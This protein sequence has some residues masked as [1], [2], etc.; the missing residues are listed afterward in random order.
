MEVATKEKDLRL[1]FSVLGF[2]AY[3][4]ADSNC[5]SKLSLFLCVTFFFFFF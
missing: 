4:L 3:S 5:V 2:P 1:G